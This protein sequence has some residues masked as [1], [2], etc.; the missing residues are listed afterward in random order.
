MPKNDPYEASRGEETA[1]PMTPE[2]KKFLEEMG[3]DQRKSKEDSD[4]RDRTR[5]K[6]MKKYKESQLVPAPGYAKGGKVK[7]SKGRG[8]GCCVKGKT[9]GRMV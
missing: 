9:K 2:R 7:A 5:A 6:E 4:E 1:P 3:E 8:D